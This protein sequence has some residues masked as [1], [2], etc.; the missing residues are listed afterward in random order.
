MTSRWDGVCFER[1]Q[2]QHVCT[3][4]PKAAIE[5]EVLISTQ[6]LQNLHSR[7]GDRAVC[8]HKVW[9][10][11]G[12][13][14]QDLA[15]PELTAVSAES[16]AWCCSKARERDGRCEVRLR[17]CSATYS[18]AGGQASWHTGAAPGPR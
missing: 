7:C 4:V 10:T 9:K 12:V 17:C 5:D 11:A 1:G 2:D 13:V 18:G 15:T 16:G 3:V 8:A 14:N 6:G